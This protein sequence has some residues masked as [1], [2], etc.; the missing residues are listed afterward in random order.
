[1]PRQ[2]LFQCSLPRTG[3]TLFQNIIS[4]D[5]RIY[6]SPNSGVLGMARFA[7]DQY[8]K[9]ADNGYANYRPI[10]SAVQGFSR[11]GIQGYYAALTDR[12]IVLD[13]S[14]GN[15]AG[16][17]VID[18]VYPNPKIICFVRSLPDIFA[19][20]E[21]LF[22]KNQ[23]R[24]YQYVDHSLMRCTTTMKRVEYWEQRF[25]SMLE[26]CRDAISTGLFDRMYFI[27]YESFCKE[28][29]KH[30][31]DIYHFWELDYRPLCFTNIQ[32]TIAEDEMI[33]EYPG[34]FD[35]RPNISQLDSDA[36]IILGT[37]ACDWIS[38]RYQWFNRYFGYT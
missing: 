13:K 28:P 17:K 22:R 18:A 38:E 3:S 37:A 21:K 5:E 23:H 12:Q 31:K 11:A 34:M 10:A 20:I 29:E 19:S 7:A 2:I 14:A 4:Q 9:A 35:I 1:M 8:M 15:F 25:R 27:K 36:E 6:A 24:S 33:Y 16:Y 26:T 32:R 30:T